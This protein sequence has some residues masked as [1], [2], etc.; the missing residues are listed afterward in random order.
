MYLKKAVLSKK[1]AYKPNLPLSEILKR[2]IF[3]LQPL[4]LLV[5]CKSASYSTNSIQIASPFSSFDQ[6]QPQYHTAL[7]NYFYLNNANFIIFKRV[8]LIN[9]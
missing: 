7:F 9:N 4:R 5:E 8:N 1:T 6:T 2:I 3:F